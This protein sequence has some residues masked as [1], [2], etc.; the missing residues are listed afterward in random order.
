MKN[1]PDP[2]LLLPSNPSNE[3]IKRAPKSCET[4]MG[5]P[6]PNNEQQTTI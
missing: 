1:K 3:I 2:A 6:I 4:V 5:Y